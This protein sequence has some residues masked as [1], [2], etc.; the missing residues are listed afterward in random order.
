MEPQTLILF[1]LV[2]IALLF[3]FFATGMSLYLFMKGNG[4]IRPLAMKT[5][6]A[7]DKQNVTFG[8]SST[9]VFVGPTKVKNGVTING[10]LYVT[11]TVFAVVDQMQSSRL[12]EVTPTGV[13]PLTHAAETPLAARHPIIQVYD[14]N[15]D[16]VRS[17]FNQFS[18]IINNGFFGRDILGSLSGVSNNIL[19]KIG[20]LNLPEID[21]SQ[22]NTSTPGLI[23]DSSFSEMLLGTLQY[24]KTAPS[25]TMHDFVYLTYRSTI[26]YNA[27]TTPTTTVSFPI[28]VIFQS[29]WTFSIDN[30]NVM[31]MTSPEGSANGDHYVLRGLSTNTNLIKAND[32][33]YV[34]LSTGRTLLAEI[35][36]GFN[37]ADIQLDASG[38]PFVSISVNAPDPVADLGADASDFA[39]YY[40]VRLRSILV[41]GF[42][43][44]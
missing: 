27:A 14:I 39:C 10:Q 16:T 15:E 8:K 20:L 36:V 35:L 40:T 13:K 30:A 2:S 3:A 42:P 43:A 34:V 22:F 32:V 25:Y 33:N 44:I 26:F 29:S 28:G 23:Q 4:P 7:A 21:S 17:S 38:R 6:L 5:V 19:Y 41:S 12:Y 11:G 18:G 1:I 9:D 24:F 31:S 37:G